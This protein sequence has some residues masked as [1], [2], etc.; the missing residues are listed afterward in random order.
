MVVALP[1]EMAMARN[2]RRGMAKAGVTRA[3][4]HKGTN[5]S[6]QITWHDLRAIGA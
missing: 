1:S 4:L 5:T 6:K 2:L 3:A